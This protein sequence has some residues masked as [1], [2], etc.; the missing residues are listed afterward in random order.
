MNGN[1]VQMQTI[2]TRNFTINAAPIKRLEPW[3]PRQTKA[4]K[5]TQND[6]KMHKTCSFV[7]S[8]SFV[9]EVQELS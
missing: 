1:K 2:E 8:R 3:R 6:K 7:I 9:G 5:Q 4:G